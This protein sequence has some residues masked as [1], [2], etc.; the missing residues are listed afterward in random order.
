MW[1]DLEEMPVIETV[2]AP[3]PPGITRMLKPFQL[4]G[5]NWMIQQEKTKWKGGLLGDEM[6]M[7]K[8]IQAVSLIMSDFPTKSPTLVVMPPVAMKQWEK[9]IQAYTDG[10]LKVH[11]YGGMTSKKLSQKELEAY[12]VIIISCMYTLFLLF[13]LPHSTR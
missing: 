10:K 7:G 6:G 4:E 12:N 8:T 9:E 1:R 2:Q 3:Q 13:P 11:I 5:L